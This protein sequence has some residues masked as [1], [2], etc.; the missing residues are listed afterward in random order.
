MLKCLRH[1][2]PPGGSKRLEMVSQW[3]PQSH[4][5]CTQFKKKTFAIGTSLRF[6]ENLDCLGYYLCFRWSSFCLV[7]EALSGIQVTIPF[8]RNIVGVGHEFEYQRKIG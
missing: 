2:E 6:F 5:S 3:F 8:M 7:V 1:D 4:R